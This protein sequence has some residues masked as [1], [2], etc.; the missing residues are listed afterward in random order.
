MPMEPTPLESEILRIGEQLSR[1]SAGLSPSLFDRRRW[2]QALINRAMKDAHVKAQLFRFIDVLPAVADDERV[3]ALA[4]DYLGRTGADLFGLQWGLK[5][6]AATGV[7]ARLSGKAIRAQVEQMARHFIAGASVAEAT[8]VL[9]GLWKEG[10]AWSVD[11][12]GEAT[13]SD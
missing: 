5:A 12:L 13:I 8:P 6:L 3:T 7:G 9:A 10:L 4:D 11:L 1:L 2:S